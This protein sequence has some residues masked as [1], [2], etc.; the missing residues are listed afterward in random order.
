MDR[1]G[2]QGCIQLLSYKESPKDTFSPRES[3]VR[4]RFRAESSKAEV[5]AVVPFMVQEQLWEKK[6]TGAHFSAPKHWRSCDE[7]LKAAGKVGSASEWG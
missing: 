3:R 5:G 7:P 4:L 2:G 6:R 1:T